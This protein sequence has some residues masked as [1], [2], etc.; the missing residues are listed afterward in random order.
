MT[1][2]GWLGIA[3]GSGLVAVCVGWGD[4][5]SVILNMPI[6]NLTLCLL[7]TLIACYAVY[8]AGPD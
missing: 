3:G 8:R 1:R 5:G 7:F 2:N 6:I 4:K